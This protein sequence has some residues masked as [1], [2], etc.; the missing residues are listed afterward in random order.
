MLVRR[1]MLALVG[2]LVAAS[3]GAAELPRAVPDTIGLSPDGL[4]RLEAV[5]RADIAQHT[6]PGAVLLIVRHGKVGYFEA[7]GERD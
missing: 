4:A 6:I 5:L 1:A 2:C 7:L 3:A